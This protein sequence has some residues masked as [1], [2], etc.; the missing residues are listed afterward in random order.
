MTS[1]PSKTIDVGCFY[2]LHFG[3][4]IT[5]DWW[6]VITWNL[7]L[8]KACLSSF[9]N[10]LHQFSLKVHPNKDILLPKV[11][12]SLNEGF[13]KTLRKRPFWGP[14][15]LESPDICKNWEIRAG[16]FGEASHIII[17]WKGFWSILKYLVNKK[18]CLCEIKKIVI[19]S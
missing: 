2:K 6:G 12:W 15:D 7:L 11:L 4:A 18:F 13:L 3:R 16:I 19:L 17:E 14:W 8:V 10:D 9:K 1:L 5:L